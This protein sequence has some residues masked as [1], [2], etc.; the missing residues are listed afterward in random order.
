MQE[1]SMTVEQ[2]IGGRTALK[3][4][5]VKSYWTTKNNYEI[6]CSKDSPQI[7]QNRLNRNFSYFVHLE[8]NTQI[9]PS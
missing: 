6:R 1:V 9:L 2:Q 3:V 4:F 7:S 8:A 5:S